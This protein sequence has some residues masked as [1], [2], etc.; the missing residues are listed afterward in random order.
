VSGWLTYG[1]DLARTSYTPERA[2]LA[3]K[4]HRAWL[5]KLRGHVASQVLAADLPVLGRTLYVGT[6]AGLV[7]AVAS[8]GTVRWTA[9]LGSLVHTCDQ[10]DSYGVIGTP[11]IDAPTSALYVADA[12]GLLHAFDLVTGAER[13]GWPVKLYDDFKSEMVWG[14]L[15]SVGGAIYVGTG[16][17][18]D[19]P[20][21]GKVIR[22]DTATGAVTSWIAVPRRLGGGGSIW[23]W[24]G[25]SYSPRRKTLLVVT[26]NAFRG[27]RNAG[28]DFSERAGFGEQLV[29]LSPKLTVRAA[30]HP[31]NISRTGDFDFV[32]APVAFSRPGCGELI[33]ALNKNGRAYLWRSGRIGDGPISSVRVAAGTLISELAYSP[34]RRALYAVTYK[35]LVRIDTAGCKL[36]VRWASPV[37][38]NLFNSSPTV[39]GNLVWFVRNAD[40]S[41]LLAVDARSGAVR[42]EVKIGQIVF[43]A[44]TVLGGTVYV[45]S[46]EDGLAAFPLR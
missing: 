42:F 46:F 27:G 10:L 1:H 7:Y 4:P 31:R 20:M 39:A 23:G 21:E 26:G 13:P 43:A 16:S 19:R 5:L 9:S 6:T 37:G 11:V 45:G 41:K 12:F 34:R 36:R 35:R 29:E 33:A 25:V 8:N 30:S 14:A 22:V 24:G 40:V 15:T 38:A 32:G 28:R 44:P 18:C 17:Y 3:A 2:P